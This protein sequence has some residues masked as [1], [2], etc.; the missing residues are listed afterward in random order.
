MRL[1]FTVKKTNK[2]ELKHSKMKKKKLH[3]NNGT[4]TNQTTK[5][6]LLYQD[7]TLKTCMVN[8]IDE[9]TK[10]RYGKMRTRYGNTFDWTQCWCKK[11][12]KL[13][14]LLVKDGHNDDANTREK[15]TQCR[16]C[17]RW[18]DS[19]ANDIFNLFFKYYLH[20]HIFISFGIWRFCSVHQPPRRSWSRD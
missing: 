17:N 1:I 11:Q 9:W 10:S 6:F 16:I 2:E 19:L 14:N 3:T 12:K 4:Y 7:I 13:D 8:E 18:N 20:F 15:W 5:I